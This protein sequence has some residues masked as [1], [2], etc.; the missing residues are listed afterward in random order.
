MAHQAKS[1]R[2]V[3]IELPLRFVKHLKRCMARCTKPSSPPAGKFTFLAYAALA[4]YDRLDACIKADL[5]YV[6]S[7]GV[8]LLEYW[9]RKMDLQSKPRKVRK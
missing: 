9:Y 8:D 7:E 6:R 5:G 1:D 3:R 2:T 4:N